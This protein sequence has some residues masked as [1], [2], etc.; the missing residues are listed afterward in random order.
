MHRQS[1]DHGPPNPGMKCSARRDG[2]HVALT[3]R[4]PGQQTPSRISSLV[5]NIDVF[6][7]LCAAACIP[8]PPHVVGRSL[9]PLLQLLNG[10]STSIRDEAFIQINFHVA[11][12]P[13][14]AIRTNDFLYIRSFPPRPDRI[15]AANIDDS[16]TK[17][18]LMT[19][20]D[21]RLSRA[22]RQLFDLRNDPDERHNVARDPAYAETVTH[23]EGRLRQ[24]MEDTDDPL[25]TGAMPQPAG[26]RQLSIE[27]IDA[28][29]LHKLR[30][31]S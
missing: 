10:T 30:A 15:R 12:D 22:P 31:T 2:T 16:P 13:T 5:S 27:S 29:E 20:G 19:E 1:H 9:L 3:I 18:A 25:L 6:P 26:T 17:Q 24:W 8:C 7:T 11:Y 23:L 4:L 28:R 21:A 14:R